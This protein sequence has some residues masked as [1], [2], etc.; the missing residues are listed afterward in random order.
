[1]YSDW[2]IIQSLMLLLLLCL[3][4]QISTFQ[5]K[6]NWIYSNC[7][8]GEYCKA[9]WG[10]KQIL[11]ETTTI[12]DYFFPYFN[13]LSFYDSE[14][15]SSS[16]VAWF[17]QFFKSN[18]QL[19]TFFWIWWKLRGLTTSET[20]L[21]FAQ[22]SFEIGKKNYLNTDI[23]IVSNIYHMYYMIHVLSIY[24]ISLNASVLAHFYE[25][26]WLSMRPLLFLWE[27]LLPWKEFCY[28]CLIGSLCYPCRPRPSESWASTGVASVTH[29]PLYP[30]S[31]V[32]FLMKCFCSQYEVKSILKE[33]YRMGDRSRF[34]SGQARNVITHTFAE[35]LP[36]WTPF[37]LKSLVFRSYLEQVIAKLWLGRTGQN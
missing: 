33:V 26:S 14:V 29:P 37:E 32:K 36:N 4:L 11:R 15:P 31:L 1:M 30:A 7:I 18:I 10:S 8:S 19:S 3:I 13:N 6:S 34:E 17:S 24:M 12:F 9:I 2:I 16:V 27:C 35:P 5:Q 23:C 20:Q 28:C 25:A 21:F 22:W